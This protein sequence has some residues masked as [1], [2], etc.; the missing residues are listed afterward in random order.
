MKIGRITILQT[1][2]FVFL[3]TLAVCGNAL[4]L[5]CISQNTRMQTV[6]GMFLVSLAVT[7]LGVGLIS[8]PVSLVSAYNPILLSNK[9]FCDLNGTSMMLFLLS[10]LLTL[11]SIS[12]QKYICVGFNKR[13]SF[14]K[15]TAKRCIAA[16]WVVSA[17]LSLAPVLGW[18]KY[19]TSKDGHQCGPFAWDIPGRIYSAC[20]LVIGFI[21]PITVMSYCYK[22][23]YRKMREHNERMRAN[24]V[25]SPSLPSVQN[26]DNRRANRLEIR[27]IYTFMVIGIVFLCCWLPSGV[28]VILEFAQVEEPLEYELFALALAYGNST[29]NPI[30]YA[31]R[32]QEFR[33][34]FKSV[35]LMGVPKCCRRKVSDSSNEFERQAYVFGNNNARIPVTV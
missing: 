29:L 6:T 14:N 30:I 2:V 22:S 28:L 26:Q 15:K 1:I 31:Y 5:Y 18:S 33:R 13:T 24:A 12:L 27:M 16:I 8:L 32:H 17:G 20:I 10:S 35:L 23:L 21:I 4:V 34:G 3:S 7:D 25:I 9:W 11:G 19:G